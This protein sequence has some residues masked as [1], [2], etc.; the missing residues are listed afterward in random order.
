MFWIG[1]YLFRY[2]ITLYLKSHTVTAD[3]TQITS[4]VEP[5]AERKKVL[6]LKSKKVTVA[7]SKIHSEPGLKPEPELQFGLVAPQ[8]RKKYFR[9]RNT[10]NHIKM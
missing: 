3:P 9:L 6:V 8:S 4:V 10:A 5:G 1:N 2:R 7:V